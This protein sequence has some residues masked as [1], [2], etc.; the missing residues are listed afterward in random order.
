MQPA[1]HAIT[2]MPYIGSMK[3]GNHNLMLLGQLTYVV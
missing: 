3:K 1:C 2:V